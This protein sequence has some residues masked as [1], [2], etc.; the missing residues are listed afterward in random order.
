MSNQLNQALASAAASSAMERAPFR[1]GFVCCEADFRRFPDAGG[2]LHGD[3]AEA[4]ESIKT[5]REVD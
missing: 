2:I 5:A 1:Q 4:S 3:S